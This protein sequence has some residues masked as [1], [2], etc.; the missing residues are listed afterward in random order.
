[1]RP[2]PQFSLQI[3]RHTCPRHDVL[4][5][6]DRLEPHTQHY[7][8]V[9]ITEAVVSRSYQ[10][11]RSN[12]GIKEARCLLLRMSMKRNDQLQIQDEHKRINHALDQ[13][14]ALLRMQGGLASDRLQNAVKELT[15]LLKRHFAF[16]ERSPL[17]LEVPLDFPRFA[18]RLQELD[19]EHKTF[20]GELDHLSTL[21]HQKHESVFIKFHSLLRRLKAHEQSE[22]EILQ[23]A[24]NQD[25]GGYQ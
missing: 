22:R 3:R 24:F 20:I 8:V 9:T 15:E 21:I 13:I 14:E 2:R 18:P 1:M 10:S 19:Q 17:Y 23:L 11:S 12:S 25:I 7:T 6:S 4:Q 5:S 16:E